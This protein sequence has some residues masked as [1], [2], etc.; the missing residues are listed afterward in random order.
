MN[1]PVHANKQI[2]L[3]NKEQKIEHVNISEQLKRAL[4]HVHAD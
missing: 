1:I 3:N 2:L 4:G